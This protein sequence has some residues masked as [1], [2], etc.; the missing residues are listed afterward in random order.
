MLFKPSIVSCRNVIQICAK[1]RTNVIGDIVKSIPATY[2]TLAPIR[3]VFFER[4]YYDA[5]C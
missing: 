5:I 2:F 4:D 3:R 1:L